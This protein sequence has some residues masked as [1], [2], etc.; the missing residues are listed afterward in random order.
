MFFKKI[1]HMAKA[2]GWKAQTCGVTGISGCSGINFYKDG[3][4]LSIS[5]VQ[6]GHMVYPDEDEL[7]EMFG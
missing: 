3:T 6:K 1:I 7:K 4:V 5:I 2:H